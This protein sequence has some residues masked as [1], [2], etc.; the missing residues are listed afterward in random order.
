LPAFEEKLKQRTDL[1]KEFKVPRDISKFIIQC[2]KRRII[3]P[4]QIMSVYDEWE[5]P[6]DAFGDEPR[7]LWRLTNA[8]T[9]VMKQK[10]INVFRN[11]PATLKLDE[12]VQEHFGIESLLN[13]EG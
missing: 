3:A 9:S 8:F 10:R 6:K 7:N 2:A 1:Y 4:N 13:G 11:A 5:E 12:I